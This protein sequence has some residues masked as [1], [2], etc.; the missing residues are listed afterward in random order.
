[1]YTTKMLIDVVTVQTESILG[2]ENTK[3]TA[4]FLMYR[5][6]S[7]IISTYADYISNIAQIFDSAECKKGYDVTLKSGDTIIIMIKKEG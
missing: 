3:N 7:E 5:K 1:M 4:E 6:L 2:V